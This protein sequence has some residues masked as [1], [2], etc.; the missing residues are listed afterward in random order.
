MDRRGLLETGAT[1][2][3]CGA[4]TAGLLRAGTGGIDWWMVIGVALGAAFA[5]AA[6]YRARVRHSGRVADAAPEFTE[7]TTTA[8]S[9]ATGG[10]EERRPTERG[11]DE[12]RTDE[13]GPSRRRAD[14]RGSDGRRSGDGE[15]GGSGR[16]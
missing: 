11:S 15:N 14:E 8:G 13:H 9:D 12:R 16:E 7:A 5:A 10:P 2:L 3:A 6:N 1:T 4:A